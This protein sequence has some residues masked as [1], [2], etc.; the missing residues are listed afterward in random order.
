MLPGVPVHVALFRSRRSVV[1]VASLAAVAAAALPAG[2]TDTASHGR[3]TSSLTILSLRIGGQSVAAGRIVAVASNASSGHVARLVVTPLAYN[4]PAAGQSGTVGQQTITP[5]SGSTTVPSAPSV[6]A[7]PNGLGSVKGPTFVAEAKDG[8]AAVLA[9]AK[10]SAL[11]KVTLAGVPLNLQAA[12]LTHEAEVVSTGATAEKSLSLGDLS[13]PSLADLLAS[14]GLDLSATLDQLTQG[15][16]TQLAGLVTTTTSGAIKT[17]NIAVDQA[18]TG[19][20]QAGATPGATLTA[21]QAQLATAQSDATAKNTA[22]DTAWSTAY[23]A[24]PALAQT[25]LSTALAAVPPPLG[26]LTVPLTADQFTA[27]VQQN[28]AGL[29]ALQVAFG[30]GETALAT[31][32]AAAVT[33]EDLAAAVNA[34]V[35][36]L[37]NLIDTVLTKVN[38]DGDPLAALGGVKLTTKAVA[39]STPRAGASLSV[40]SI[41]VLGQ[42]ASLSTVTGALDTVGSTLASVLNSVPGVTFTPPSI[43]VGKPSHSTR[44][45]GATRYATASV[46]GVTVNMPTL[47]LSGAALPLALPGGVTSGAGA[48]VLG[49]LTESASFT[50]GAVSNSPVPGGASGPQLSETGGKILLPILATVLLGVAVAVRRRWSAA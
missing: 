1:A 9:A 38:A 28:G 43:A 26:P 18:Q 49:D 16:L 12:S 6:I 21:A 47:D 2:A 17:A 39:A 27:L 19:V 11:G 35:D 42:A 44:T 8:A 50:P 41:D 13:L 7:L 3:A 15:K 30:A 36:A 34:L 46:R 29:A 31:A 14:L 33:A 45:S 25:T 5:S 23:G 32:A 37:Q 40:A 24:L 48:L 4:F 22:F 10:L 20:T